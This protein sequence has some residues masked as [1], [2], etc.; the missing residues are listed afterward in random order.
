MIEQSRA[1]P[2]VLIVDDEAR[3]RKTLAK[4]LATKG[5][6]VHTVGSG[7]EAV[8][9]V[10]QHPVDVI[11]L[12][13]RMPGMNGIDTLSALKRLDPLLEVIMLTGHASVDVAVEIMRRGGYE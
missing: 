10:Q 7:E 5:I 2:T 4:L 11:L 13:M 12:D 8:S 6:D 9:F 1:K 3:F